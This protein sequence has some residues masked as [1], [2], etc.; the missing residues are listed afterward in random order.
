MS[1]YVPNFNALMKHCCVALFNALFFAEQ[2]TIGTDKIIFFPNSLSPHQQNYSPPETSD[3]PKAAEN[4]RYQF[5]LSMQKLFLFHQH[6]ELYQH[7]F[8]Q[9]VM[10]LSI[11]LLFPIFSLLQLKSLQ[12][13]LHSFLD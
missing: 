7:L 4:I 3:R 2:L 13:F 9:Q 10:L 5:S 12:K 11:D 8:Y 6:R 1:F